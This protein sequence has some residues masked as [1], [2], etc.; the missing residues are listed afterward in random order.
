MRRTAINFIGIVAAVVVS[1]AEPLGIDAARALVG[2]AGGAQ[3]RAPHAVAR[4]SV[5]FRSLVLAAVAV[6]VAV[7]QPRFRYADALGRRWRRCGRRHHFG[8]L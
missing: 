1:V 5:A 4:G 3:T 2:A 8:T 6:D 7:A